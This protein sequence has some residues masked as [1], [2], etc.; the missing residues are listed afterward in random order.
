MRELRPLL[1]AKVVRASLSRHKDANSASAAAICVVLE[2]LVMGR[3]EFI[4]ETRSADEAFTT[5]IAASNPGA[6]PAGLSLLSST[7][8]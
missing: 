8:S 6:S 7:S 3:S 5:T 2:S 4:A 1:R